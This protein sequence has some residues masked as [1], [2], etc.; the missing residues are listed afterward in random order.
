MASFSYVA[1]EVK[2][3]VENLKRQGYR[4]EDLRKLSVRF[5]RDKH[6]TLLKYDL[7]NGNIFIKELFQAE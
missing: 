4:L 1:V 6:D 5:F 7:N 2:H 3:S